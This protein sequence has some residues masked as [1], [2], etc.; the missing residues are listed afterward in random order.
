LLAALLA[1]A[2]LSACANKTS[3]DDWVDTSP[4]ADTTIADT[5]EPDLVEPEDVAVPDTAPPPDTTGLSDIQ[6]MGC[7]GAPFFLPLDYTAVRM[8]PSNPVIKVAS[9]QSAKA[10]FQIIAT[11]VDGEE[12]VIQDVYFQLSAPTL[13]DITA[14]GAFTSKTGAGG[15]A[16]VQGI[17]S[18]GCIETTITVITEF[19]QLTE[20][21]S[22]NL[23]LWF[24]E[25]LANDDY[26]CKDTCNG[27]QDDWP[28]QCTEG[29]EFVPGGCCPD[30]V[31]SCAEP[32]ALNTPPTLLYPLDG[33]AWPSNLPAAVVQWSQPKST[34][35]SRVYRIAFKA[36]FAHIYVY[37]TETA[38]TA[39]NN[40]FAATVPAQSWS[41]LWAL[42]GGGAHRVS[43]TSARMA[44][45]GLVGVIPSQSHMMNTTKDKFGGAVYYWNIKHKGI[46]VV[47]LSKQPP[48]DESVNIGGNCH[49][50]H[51]ASPD[52]E[53]I[54]ATYNVGPIPEQCGAVTPLDL[55][56]CTNP[57]DTGWVYN[58][59]TKKCSSVSGCNCG[60]LCDL[61]FDTEEECSSH[62]KAKLWTMQMH[63]VETG[64]K[65]D[66]VHPEAEA[67]LE[68]G[69]VMYPAFSDTYW[70]TVTKHVVVSQGNSITAPGQSLSRSLYSVDL[71][72][73]TIWQMTDGT[74]PNM[75]N[76]Q[77]F[78]AFSRN[79]EYV[80]FASSS[81]T[82]G[83]GGLG[84]SGDSQ[85]WRIPYNGGLGGDATPIYG[86]DDPDLLQYYPAITPDD[87]YVVFNRA[88]ADTSA[89]KGQSG[90]TGPGGAGTYD[91]CLAELWIIPAGGGV[92][93]RLGAASG[94]PESGY[95]NS[96]PSMTDKNTGNY[97]WVAFSSRRPYGVLK[98]W[99][100]TSDDGP[101]QAIG[102]GGS[103][104][105]GLNEPQL[106]VAAINPEGIDSDADPSFAPIWLPGQES[107]GGNH[108]GQWS[109]R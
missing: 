68:G 41:N 106:W 52:G 44:D 2:L 108:I 65:V 38:W 89:C 18:F 31:A 74:D 78:P 55:Q 26:S 19:H 93:V 67:F 47:D 12:E 73:G 69:G 28:C 61:L 42:G 102:T 50:C 79:G 58:T 48:V 22:P 80:V 103:K 60:A 62:C 46:R 27:W 70:K 3:P 5:A 9:H 100:G 49:G 11:N 72:D 36:P 45:S 29:C 43:I 64:A 95:A 24:Q 94:P 90:K 54:A 35:G 53:T 98:N 56:P 99:T 107:D 15:A 14:A 97:Y 40:A 63:D 77:L 109:M 86:A 92:P 81:N 13:G 66:Y 25:A 21:A 34:D 105:S 39:Q 101:P 6:V 91:N 96:W 76:Q 87:T 85:L 16:P 57:T 88:L 17:A 71:L 8:E 10:N 7:G 4:P 20:G 59:A 75:G 82:S 33:S 51:A 1:T 84:I 83:K 23:P 30:Y 32:D 37:G 104:E